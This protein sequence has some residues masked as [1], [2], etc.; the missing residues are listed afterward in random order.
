MGSG[1]NMT[2]RQRR[3]IKVWQLLIARATNRQTITYTELL[4]LIDEPVILPPNVGRR[5]LDPVS[6]F[7]AS[8]NMPNLAV[9]VV[10]RNTGAPGVGVTLSLAQVNLERE[11]VFAA[12]WFG[13][14]PPSP[15][16]F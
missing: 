8:R 2:D 9:L 5:L 3:C 16:E 6:E 12:A 15:E 10:N 13:V 1:W 14:E 4:E 7:C 11:E